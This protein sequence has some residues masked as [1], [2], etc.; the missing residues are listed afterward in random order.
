MFT[1]LD[2]LVGWLGMGG[3]W[4]IGLRRAGG[5]FYLPEPG[6]A[7]SESAGVF[8]GGMLVVLAGEKEGFWGWWCGLCRVDG[9]FW[10]SG[11]RDSV[12]ISPPPE[13]HNNYRNMLV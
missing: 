7:P 12:I 9:A 11:G 5:G 13:H 1:G 3:R 4:A 10:E 8:G 2:W 6:G